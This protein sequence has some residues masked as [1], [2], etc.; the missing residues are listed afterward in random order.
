MFLSNQEM[1][2]SWT[3]PLHHSSNFKEWE[4]LVIFQKT[5]EIIKIN[6]KRKNSSF[7]LLIISS[8]ITIIENKRINYYENKYLCKEILIYIDNKR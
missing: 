4:I 6:N 2:L 7:D 3:F 1:T 8:M 5:K